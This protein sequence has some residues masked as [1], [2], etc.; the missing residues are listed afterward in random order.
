MTTLPE[1]LLAA[2]GQ[3]RIAH[4]SGT[5]RAVNYKFISVEDSTSS[6][7]S[8]N[9]STPDESPSDENSTSDDIPALILEKSFDF[10]LLSS[11]AM[12][13]DYSTDE[14]ST[15]EYSSDEDLLSLL[16]DED[17]EDMQDHQMW[18][19]SRRPPKLWAP[20][21]EKWFTAPL[22]DSPPTSDPTL[23]SMDSRLPSTTTNQANKTIQQDLARV[24][25]A[26]NKQ[27]PSDPLPQDPPNRK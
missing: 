8:S 18:S 2:K 22:P 21:Q 10:E 12:S 4:Y 13:E 7:Y 16:P 6:G 23:H 9:T 24:H 1:P 26:L 3:C 15:D 19:P 20:G 17:S 27:A 5:I 25:A 14:Y 11:E